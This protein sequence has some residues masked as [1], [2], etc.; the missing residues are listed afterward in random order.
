MEELS[1]EYLD[2]LQQQLAALHEIIDAL[3]GEVLAAVSPALKQNLW[4]SSRQGFISQTEK[5]RSVDSQPVSSG[6]EFPFPAGVEITIDVKIQILTT[7]LA[8]AYC[9]I[10]ELENKLLA[11]RNQGK[12]NSSPLDDNQ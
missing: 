8:E 1:Q 7:Q 2:H 9:R 3:P 5:A 11:C 6:S 12:D 4:R 10:T